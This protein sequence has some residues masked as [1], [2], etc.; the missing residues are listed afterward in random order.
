MQKGLRFLGIF[1]CSSRR[2]Y[3][4]TLAEVLIT[5]GII[6]VISAK[7]IPQLIANTQK[8]V[9]ETK[10]V[11]FMADI[12]QTYRLS[13]AENGVDMDGWFDK[14]KNYS[15]ADMEYFV[16]NYIRPYMNV[17]YTKS[18]ERNPQCPDSERILV[19]MNNGTAFS[20]YVDKNG[21]DIH[22]HP[23]AEKYT[24]NNPR[25]SYG[26]QVAKVKKSGKYDNYNSMDFVEPYVMDW[27]GTLSMLKNDSA[28]G[29]NRTSRNK[30]Y[31]TKYIQMNNWK[32]PADYPW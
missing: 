29:C 31:C 13:A 4:F 12:N 20:M 1:N 21:V 23:D 27:D 10:L 18:I 26:F 9:T 2:R 30:Q 22:F 17:S 16:E 19:V 3:A 5:L 7:V 28:R 32:I 25:Y 11:H 6:G 8:R 14:Q 24:Y 15:Q